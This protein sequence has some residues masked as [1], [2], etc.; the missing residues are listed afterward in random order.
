ARG[1]PYADHRGRIGDAMRTAPGELRDR[2]LDRDRVHVQRG[3]GVDPRCGLVEDV[4][5]VLRVQLLER[6]QVG[7]VEDRPEVDVEAFRPL[8]SE[9]LDAAGEP[10]YRLV[11]QTGVVRGGQRPDV[12][13]RAGEPAPQGGAA[14]VPDAPHAVE[15]A[16]GP[17]LAAQ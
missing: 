11:C 17:V 6:P 8:A 5:P 9:D 2:H 13:G 7:Q 1:R 12:A 14:A 10:V 4:Q 15:L 16:A 3:G